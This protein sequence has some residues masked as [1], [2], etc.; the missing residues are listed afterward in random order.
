MNECPVSFHFALSRS[1]KC[2][3]VLKDTFS[4]LQS[5]R[6]CSPTIPFQAYLITSAS[7]WKP[8]ALLPTCLLLSGL[9]SSSMPSAD[10]PTACSPRPINYSLASR[11]HDVELCFRHLK[12]TL[13]WSSGYH[14]TRSI[15]E[16]LLSSTLCYSTNHESTSFTCRS[17]V[18]YGFRK[19]IPESITS[20]LV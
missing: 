5:L 3:R 1:T 4:H 11:Y 17:L 20:L 10:H 14:D 18:P 2:G 7:T 15:G 16:S 19:Y 13:R 12:R 9:N 6:Y 8:Y